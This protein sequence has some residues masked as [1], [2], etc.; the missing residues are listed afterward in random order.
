MKGKLDVESYTSVTYVCP[1]CHSDF[2]D[3]EA[4]AE[5][6]RDTCHEAEGIDG[7]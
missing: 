1:Y 6:C 7:K 2:E 5:E 3:S 4:E